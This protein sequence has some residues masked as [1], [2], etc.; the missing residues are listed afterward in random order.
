[1]PHHASAAKRVI[2][3]ERSRQRN[4]AVK[5]R[6]RAAIKS[7]RQASDKAAAQQALRGVV[8]V[9]DR[10]AAKGIITRQTASR[11]KSRLARHLQRMSAT[12]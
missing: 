2:T 5:T 1:M 12:A 8:S 4:A 3:S 7:V 9:L 11:H 6:I 10:A